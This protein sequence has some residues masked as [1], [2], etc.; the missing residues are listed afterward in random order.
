MQQHL[1]RAHGYVDQGHGCD[2]CCYPECRSSDFDCPAD[3]CHGDTFANPGA[4]RDR[5]SCAAADGHFRADCDTSDR[6]PDSCAAPHADGDSL[7][8]ADQNTG[9]HSDDCAH[10]NGDAHAKTCPGCVQP[11]L[12]H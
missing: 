5:H 11:A 6:D 1:N 8:N 7:A 10:S 9:T 3:C 12:G 2:A 4:C